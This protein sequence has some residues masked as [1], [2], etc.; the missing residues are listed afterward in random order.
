MGANIEIIITGGM[1]TLTKDNAD[2][3]DRQ[4]GPK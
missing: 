4:K 1:D 2:E 3:R